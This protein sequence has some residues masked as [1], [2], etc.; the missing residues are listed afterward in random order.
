[1]CECV[2]E[3]QERKKKVLISTGIICGHIHSDKWSP[4]WTHFIDSTKTKT[5]TRGELTQELADF[6]ELDMGMVKVLN[7]GLDVILSNGVDGV[8]EGFEGRTGGDL[9]GGRDNVEPVLVLCSRH[10]YQCLQVSICAM[11]W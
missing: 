2:T 6:V 11:F 8:D 10:C 4:S 3:H 5:K 9:D 7:N 1:M